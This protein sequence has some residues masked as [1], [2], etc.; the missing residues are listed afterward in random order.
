MQ[1]TFFFFFYRW[2]DKSLETYTL[3]GLEFEHDQY[4]KSNNIV[5]AVEL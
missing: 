5:I 3:R 2:N 1:I 4:I